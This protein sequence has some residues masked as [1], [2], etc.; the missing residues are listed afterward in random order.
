MSTS[1]S[2]L[3]QKDAERTVIRPSPGGRRPRA[4]RRSTGFSNHSKV[5]GKSSFHFEATGDNPL[6]TGSFSLLS[7]VPELRGQ[8]FHE[9]ANLLQE[10]MITAI[11]KFEKS[12]LQKGASRT[13]VNIAKYFLCSLLDETVLNTP[14]GSQSGWGH[15]S[16][17]SLFFKKL[18]GGE[19]FFQILDRLKE[20]PK[21]NQNLLEMAYLCLSLGFEG[22]YR[23]R[24]NGLLAIERQREELFLLIRQFRGD[25]PPELSTRW[26]GTSAIQNPL[27]RFIPLWVL[28]T[29]TGVML[30]FIYMIFAYTI[31]DK[32]DQ[33]Y[34]QLFTV[35]KHIEKGSQ[36]QLVQPIVVQKPVVSLNA[37]FGN[38]LADEIAQKKVALIDGKVLR[39]FDMFLSGSAEIKP[40]YEPL[41]YKIA[42]AV[43]AENVRILIK[44]HT[45]NQ[46]IKF[47]S[48]YD[49]NWQLSSARAESAAMAFSQNGLPKTRINS[50]G[51]ADKEPIA[52]NDTEADRA[53][54]RRIDIYFR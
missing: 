22:K 50:E 52:P 16:L 1:D 2:I 24:N 4:P 43:N 23:Y 14:W 42:K 20:Q 25:V 47:S 27:I 29:V 13:Q 18:V 30:L 39:I 19:E 6:L 12:A 9:A 5:A 48:W 54:N 38:L 34:D 46:K 3:K 26:Q 51:L 10:R 35:A 31:R 11:K 17:S 33:L 36:M 15:N 40:E 21:Q 44:G 32:S 53:L 45:D 49:S 7:L 8:T 41:M 28:A 37:L